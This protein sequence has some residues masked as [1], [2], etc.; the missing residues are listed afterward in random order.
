ALCGQREVS[1]VTVTSTQYGPVPQWLARR[2]AD[3]PAGLSLCT[4][5]GY[6]VGASTAAFRPV[7]KAAGRA[8]HGCARRN[9]RQALS[10]QVPPGWRERGARLESLWSPCKTNENVGGGQ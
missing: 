10:R 2:Q 9:R 3:T 4:A 5:P 8:C 1:V 7:V 6:R